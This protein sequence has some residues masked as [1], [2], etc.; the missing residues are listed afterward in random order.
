MS[1]VAGDKNLSLREQR[2]KAEKEAEKAENAALK[3]RLKAEKLRSNRLRK[4]VF[5]LGA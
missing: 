4:F 3:A 1:R 5:R 2:F